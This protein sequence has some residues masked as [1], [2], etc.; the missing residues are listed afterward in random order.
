[1]SKI[2]ICLLAIA[3]STGCSSRK[4]DLAEDSIAY[5][6]VFDVEAE[7]GNDEN[8][9]MQNAT[10][11]FSRPLGKKIPEGYEY[12]EWHTYRL[13]DDYTSDPLRDW[14]FTLPIEVSMDY[15]MVKNSNTG[16]YGIVDYDGNFTIEAKY[17]ELKF[18]YYENSMA[19]FA[20]NYEGKIDVVDINNNVSDIVLSFDPEDK[21]HYCGEPSL[22]KNSIGWYVL[23][24]DFSFNLYNQNGEVLGEQY[25]DILLFDEVYY[26]SIGN[27]RKGST[28][29]FRENRGDDVI[30]FYDSMDN[31]DYIVDS[32]NLYDDASVCGI[33][34]N[35]K[36][37]VYKKNVGG[38]IYIFNYENS[39]YDKFCDGY[40]INCLGDKIVYSN[41]GTYKAVELS[42]NN[43]LD[44]RYYGY[45]I[46]CDTYGLLKREDG[47]WIC[48]D[49]EGNVHINDVLLSG[50]EEEPENYKNLSII[51]YRIFEGE[52]CVMVE[53]ND[54]VVGY[55]LI[56]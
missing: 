42:G 9:I 32:S 19:Y 18:C 24:E 33:I 43:I 14:D 49:Q 36:T 40:F 28:I 13:A 15:T 50:G 46:V 12:E 41:N 8:L 7:T 38:E 56:N 10:R 2:G 52:P 21:N 27:N 31:V 23:Q 6:K 48:I 5:E 37:A 47:S 11:L 44:E 17:N 30:G 53:E 4:T 35:A 3:I 25:W 20:R 51:G 1:M 34:R 29:Y 39:T 54:Q 22:R 55:S 45:L 16:M 26:H